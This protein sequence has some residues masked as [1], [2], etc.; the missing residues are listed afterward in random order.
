M[1][2][3][4]VVRS[5]SSRASQRPEMQLSNYNDGFA[6]SVYGSRFVGIDLPRDHMPESEMPRDVAYRMIKD[7]LSLDNNPMFN[8]ASLVTTYMV[9]YLYSYNTYSPLSFALETIHV[10]VP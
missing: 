3:L 8:L 2:H 1:A 10:L 9:N 6:T 4:S 7:D 5:I